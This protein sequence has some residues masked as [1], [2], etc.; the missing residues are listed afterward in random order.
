[1]DAHPNHIQ[2][3]GDYRLDGIILHN[4]KNEGTF[5]SGSAGINI[6]DLVL[7]MNIYEGINKSSVT[8]SLVIGDAINL[9]G[10]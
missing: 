10:N 5:G 7:E 8:G 3:A 4:H 2:F 9:I 1:M 6:Q